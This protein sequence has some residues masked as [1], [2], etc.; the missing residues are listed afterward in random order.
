MPCQSVNPDHCEL[1]QPFGIWMNK[2]STHKNAAWQLIQ[3]IT[4]KDTQV[5]ATRPRPC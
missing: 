1:V 2:A 3:Y 5:A 4:S